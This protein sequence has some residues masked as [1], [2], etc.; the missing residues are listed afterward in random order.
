MPIQNI[1]YVC[2]VDCKGADFIGNKFTHSLA[3]SLTYS[4]L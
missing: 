2:G 4:A 1:Y 3:H